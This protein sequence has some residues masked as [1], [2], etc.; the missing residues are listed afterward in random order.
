MA[1]LRQSLEDLCLLTSVEIDEAGVHAGQ[2]R[3][4][5][6]LVDRALGV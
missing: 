4:N 2:V 1:D 6:E 5:N 3:M